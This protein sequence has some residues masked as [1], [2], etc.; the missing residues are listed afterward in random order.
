MEKKL[1]FILCSNPSGDGC[2][3]DSTCRL[4]VV[5]SCHSFEQAY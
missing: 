4:K 5:V 1:I 2:T 3:L